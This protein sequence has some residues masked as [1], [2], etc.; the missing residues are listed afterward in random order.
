MT[1]TPEVLT[2]MSEGE[3][4]PKVTKTRDDKV[5]PVKL[6]RAVGVRTRD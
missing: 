1:L 5:A 3:K 4:I 6:A 2:G